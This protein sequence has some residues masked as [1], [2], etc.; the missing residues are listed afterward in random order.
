MEQ[1]SLIII[2]IV[3]LIIL[4]LFIQNRESLENPEINK[5]KSQI[6][7]Y[8]DNKLS[9]ITFK[10]KYGDKLSSLQILKLVGAYKKGQLTNDKISKI[11][12]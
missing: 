4:F 6:K 12:S 11:L 8:I 2:I 7:D 10:A 9:I 5:I 3:I 1:K